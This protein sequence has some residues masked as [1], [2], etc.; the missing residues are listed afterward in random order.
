MTLYRHIIFLLLC[1]SVLFSSCSKDESD[2]RTDFNPSICFPPLIPNLRNY[3]FATRMSEIEEEPH[4]HR[5]PPHIFNCTVDCD[6][7]WIEDMN[8]EEILSYEVYD[9]SGE[10]V[11][12]F[13]NEGN[14]ISFIGSAN[15]L[16]TVCFLTQDYCFIGSTDFSGS[17]YSTDSDKVLIFKLIRINYVFG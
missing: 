6:G 4:G 5:V 8:M 10:C 9:E 16:Y 14:F 17:K 7:V 2:L 12:L 11:G 15:G 13:G 3:P 1:S